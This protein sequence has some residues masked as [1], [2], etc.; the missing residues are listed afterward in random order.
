MRP[1]TGCVLVRP[2]YCPPSSAPDCEM[3][4]P[5]ALNSGIQSGCN[6]AHSR[7]A[8]QGGNRAILLLPHPTKGCGPN[9]VRLVRH[10]DCCG[11]NIGCFLYIRQVTRRQPD[12]IVSPAAVK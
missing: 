7:P 10:R 11:H 6:P 8:T 3:T 5:L 12:P 2:T 1:R 4:D 9:S